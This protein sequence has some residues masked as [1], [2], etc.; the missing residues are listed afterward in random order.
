MLK[1]PITIG[2]FSRLSSCETSTIRFLLKS[3]ISLL[4]VL[5]SFVYGTF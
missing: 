5:F 2:V 1:V 4:K 3:D